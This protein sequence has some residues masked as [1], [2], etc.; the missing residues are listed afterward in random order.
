[1]TQGS[2]SKNEGKHVVCKKKALRAQSKNFLWGELHWGMLPPGKRNNHF[3]ICIP[4]YAI[5]GGQAHFWGNW[6]AFRDVGSPWSLHHLITGLRE[7]WEGNQPGSACSLWVSSWSIFLAPQLGFWCERRGSV[8]WAHRH[9]QVCRGLSAAQAT[10]VSR[11][12]GV[13]ED[14]NEGVLTVLP[15]ATA[16]PRAGPRHTYHFSAPPR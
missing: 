15:A 8:R 11:R 1:M 12:W 9:W 7:A 6:A 5:L 2:D 14:W 3:L 10:A 4:N 16:W 13:G